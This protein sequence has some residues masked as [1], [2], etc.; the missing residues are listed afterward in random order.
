MTVTIIRLKDNIELISII[1]GIH[2]DKLKTIH[3]H[4]IRFDSESNMLGIMPYCPLSDEIRFDI[5]V[6]RIEF[7]VEPKRIVRQ[8]YLDMIREDYPVEMTKEKPKTDIDKC[9]FVDGNSTK[10]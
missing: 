4:Y 9:I 1:E 10:H 5:A 6:D 2:D 8:R 3:P 7:M